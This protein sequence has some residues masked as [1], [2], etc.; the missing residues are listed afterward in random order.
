MWLKCVNT[1]PLL[2]E[3]GHF[4]QGR[5]RLFLVASPALKEQCAVSSLFRCLLSAI[6][7]YFCVA[8]WFVFTAQIA[9]YLL[10]SWNRVLFQSL[11]WANRILWNLKVCYR[12]HKSPPVVPIMSQINPFHSLQPIYLGRSLIIYSHLRLGL[13]SG[14]FPSDFPT[15]TLYASFFPPYVL[16]VSAITRINICWRVWTLEPSLCRAV[17]GL[18]EP[19]SN[20]PE[21]L[22]CKTSQY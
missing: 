16:R 2:V 7:Y 14:H 22:E 10:T 21:S 3:I 13:T 4:A 6:L 8:L 11:S 12:V 20:I 19:N 18:Y 5:A 15:Q 1:F 17:L 9:L